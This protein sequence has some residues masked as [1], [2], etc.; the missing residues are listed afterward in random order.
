MGT[1]VG[2]MSCRK[3]TGGK[4]RWGGLAPGYLAQN[5]K[6]QRKEKNQLE[7]DNQSF[8]AVYRSLKLTLAT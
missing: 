8:T 2:N 3:N 1:K 5:W 4:C 6:G 7:A